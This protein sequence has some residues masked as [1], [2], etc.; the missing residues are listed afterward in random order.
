MLISEYLDRRFN[1]WFSRF[2]TQRRKTM[3]KRQATGDGYLDRCDVARRN[4]FGNYDVVIFPYR[5]FNDDNLGSSD[6][7]L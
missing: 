6:P 5:P 1:R 3:A 7:W 2:L 4:P